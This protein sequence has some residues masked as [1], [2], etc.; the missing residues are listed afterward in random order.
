MD[1]NLNG[2]R[3]VGIWPDQSELFEKKEAELQPEF[4][5]N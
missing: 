4:S 5:G 3:A 2:F 1:S